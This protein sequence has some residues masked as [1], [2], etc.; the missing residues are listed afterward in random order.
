MEFIFGAKHFS[1]KLYFSTAISI[2]LLISNSD[3]YAAGDAEQGQRD[4]EY[5]CK[6][7]HGT[8]QPGKP[9][10]FS[11]FDISANRLSVYASDPAAIAKAA[12]EGYVIPKG[13]SN[14]DYPP[15]ARTSLPMDS[16]AGSGQKRFGTGTN[17]STY[18]INISAYFASLF[19]VPNAPMIGTVIVGDAQVTVNFTAPKS[20]LT[21]TSY[22]V[23]ATPGGIAATGNASPITVTGLT[24]GTAY[25]FTVTATSNAG[26]SKPSSASNS[27]TPIVPVKVAPA[28]VVAGQVVP[29][30]QAKAAVPI[31]TPVVSATQTKAVTLAE[32]VVPNVQ[33]KAVVPVAPVTPPTLAVPVDQAKVATPIAAP[34]KPASAV[35]AASQVASATQTKAAAPPVLVVPSVQAKVPV[36]PPVVTVT[37][38]TASAKATTSNHAS[39]QKIVLQTPTMKMARAGSASARVFFGAPADS[40]SITGYT[41]TTLSGGAPTGIIAT[42]TK[43]PIT[44]SGLTNG[45]AY[46]FTI[47]ANS[48]AGISEASEQS[49][50]VTPL[51]ILGD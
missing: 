33:A 27:V 12:N 38:S 41:V 40:A 48:S 15:G 35:A 10:A 47:T 4:F 16:F 1:K 9:G 31:P 29:A 2:F 11:D 23:T 22:T 8:P 26:S 7:C 49:N 6:H 28:V 44:I 14:N 5:T 32:P 46:T 50:A 30:P 24:N 17:P 20:D 37:N 19:P 34:P 36:A 3:V 21:I 51:G 45:T 13:N 39:T 43:S 42:G 25:N 18:V